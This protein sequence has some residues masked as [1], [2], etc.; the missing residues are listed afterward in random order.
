MTTLINCH[1]EVFFTNK[2]K[3]DKRQKTRMLGNFLNWEHC[4][5]SRS[6]CNILF[7]PERCCVCYRNFLELFKKFECSQLSID[8]PITQIF[9]HME[10]QTSEGKYCE[11]LQLKRALLFFWLP[12]KN[13]ALQKCQREDLEGR[14]HTSCIDEVK[15]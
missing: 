11:S 10:N 12:Q 4:H 8:S 1:N 7:V 5:L 6:Q 2:K 14:S 3:T 9:H 13:S 15:V